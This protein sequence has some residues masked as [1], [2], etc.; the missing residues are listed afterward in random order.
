V[1]CVHVEI[2]G[3]DGQTHGLTMQASSLFDAA[4]KAMDAWS[5]LWW[6]DFSTIVLVKSGDER[7]MIRQDRIQKWRGRR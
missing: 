4:A 5:K 3:K 1:R 7:W 6:F 2:K